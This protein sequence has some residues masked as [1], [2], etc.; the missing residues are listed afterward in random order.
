MESTVSDFESY[1]ACRILEKKVREG[2]PPAAMTVEK[3]T[4]LRDQA[5]DLRDEKA[6]QTL[7]ALAGASEW[8]EDEWEGSL[9]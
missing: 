2:A 3:Y 5:F 9:R 7:Y 1:L 4:Q 8:K 6:A